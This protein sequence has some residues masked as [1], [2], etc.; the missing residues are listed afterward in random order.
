MQD[1]TYSVLSLAEEEQMK[2]EEGAQN[3]ARVLVQP[4]EYFIYVTGRRLERS[5]C[6]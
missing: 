2:Q 6:R 3:T 4:G 1:V 5:T